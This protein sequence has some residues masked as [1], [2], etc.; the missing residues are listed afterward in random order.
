MATCLSLHTTAPAA[1]TD[2]DPALDELSDRAFLEAAAD[3]LLVR[4]RAEV[5]ELVRAAAWAD[6]S[7]HPRDERD[8]MTTPGGDGTPSV[9]EYAIPDLA[10]AR[11]THP[12]TTR[13]LMADALDLRHRLPR[14]WAV[15]AAGK[16][17]PWV[18]RKVAVISR[19]LLADVVGVVDRAVARAISRPRPIHRARDRTGQGDRGRPRNPRR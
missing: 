16:C 9:R 19:G 17:E 10:M 1:L 7:S 12:A 5:A 13:A 15:V 14:T 2:A 8:P 3:D 6:R 11:E 18:A 4:R